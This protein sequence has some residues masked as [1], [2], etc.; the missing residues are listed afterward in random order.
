MLAKNKNTKN[1]STSPGLP[2]PLIPVLIILIPNA[3]FTLRQNPLIP[4]RNFRRVDLDSLASFIRGHFHK[5]VGFSK[6]ALAVKNGI[7]SHGFVLVLV[8]FVRILR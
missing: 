1:A 6:S 5:I 3:R 7:V 4:I 2:Y 8:F